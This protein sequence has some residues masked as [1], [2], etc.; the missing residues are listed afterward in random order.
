ML[1]PGLENNH[2]LKCCSGN[3]P[4]I[5]VKIVGKI[6]D[7]HLNVWLFSNPGDKVQKRWRTMGQICSVL[8][9][10]IWTLSPGLENNHTLRCWSG[11]FPA[12]LTYM[13]RL[14]NSQNNISVYRCSPIQ[15]TK[16]YYCWNLMKPGFQSGTNVFVSTTPPRARPRGGGL[17]PGA[18]GRRRRPGAQGAGHGAR[19]VRPSVP[20]SPPL[21]IYNYWPCPLAHFFIAPP[22]S[23]SELLGLG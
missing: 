23:E 18:P 16:F 11:I 4:I 14:E 9:T 6:S 1:S 7:Q 10:R 5:C 12:I 13:I 21:L 20:A 3:F 19:P 22:Q 17:R 8:S 2:T 15:G